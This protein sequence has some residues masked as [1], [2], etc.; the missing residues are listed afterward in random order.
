VC[1]HAEAL[2]VCITAEAGMKFRYLKSTPSVQLFSPFTN[3][4][5]IMY[6]RG[7]FQFASRLLRLTLRLLYFMYEKI[8]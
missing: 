6:G 4:E 3:F 2:A 5:K 7:L 1:G 8:I